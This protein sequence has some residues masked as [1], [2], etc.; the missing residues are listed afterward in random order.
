MVALA[1]DVENAIQ[2]AVIGL[3]D[4]GYSW[5]EIANRLGIGRQAAR[6][7]WNTTD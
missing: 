3:R 5:T 2:T 1:Q 7:R 4:F 6:Q